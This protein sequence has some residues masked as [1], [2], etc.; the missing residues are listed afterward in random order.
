LQRTHPA[1]EV[2]RIVDQEETSPAEIRRP[3]TQAA[4]LDRV[5]ALLGARSR[6][7]AASMS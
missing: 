7:A 3:F 1:L 4:L 5:S 6:L 2:L